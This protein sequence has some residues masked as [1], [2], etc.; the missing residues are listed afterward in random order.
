MTIDTIMQSIVESPLAV[1]IAEDP[2]LFPWLELAHVLAIT[3]VFGSILLVDLRLMGLAARDYPIARLSK[4]V[5]P[6]T[7][8]AFLFAAATGSLLFISN[9]V[10]YY[11]N[12]Y[13]RA[14]I[15]L[16]LCAGLNMAIFHVWTWRNVSQWDES[17]RVP[18]A[19]RFAGVISALLWVAIIV[20]GRW[21][22]FTMAPF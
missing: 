8:V 2:V 9:A 21:I 22:G 5:V 16:M 1:S 12:V 18:T 20:C 14:K 10:T 11:G 13:F 17:P 15:L 7:W 3:I 4:A 19:V 6:V